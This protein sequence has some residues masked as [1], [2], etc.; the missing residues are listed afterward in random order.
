M[1]SKEK[2]TPIVL[3]DQN[4]VIYFSSFITAIHK[5]LVYCYKYYELE[6]NSP[7]NIIFTE[8]KTFPFSFIT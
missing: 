5:S 8:M 4:A 3:S 2:K 6:N 1:I 7:L